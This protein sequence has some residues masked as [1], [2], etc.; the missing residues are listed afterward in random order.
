MKKLQ[1]EEEIAWFVNLLSRENVRSYLEIGSKFGGSLERVAMALRA[2]SRI[3]SVDMPGGTG[4]SRPHLEACV[5]RLKGHGYDAHLIL[6]DST[7]PEI[8]AQA[9]ALGPFDAVFIDANHL[10]PYVT[11]DWENYG[12]LGRIVAFHDIAYVPKPGNPK[13]IEVPQFWNSIKGGYRFEECKL[14]GPHNG[15]GV[16]WR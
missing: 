4:A 9:A 13:E 8:I 3:V 14:D 11:K 6:G 5:E 2:G 15:I 7:A 16:L 1:R 12:P 10:L